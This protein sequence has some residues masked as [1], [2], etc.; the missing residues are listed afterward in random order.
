MLYQGEVLIAIIALGI[1]LSFEN[2]E[3]EENDETAIESK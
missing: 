3:Y 2:V 1:V